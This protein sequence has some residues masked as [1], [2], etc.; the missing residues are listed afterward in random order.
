[1]SLFKHVP[2][3]HNVEVTRLVKKLYGISCIA[4]QLPSERDQNFRLTSDTGERFVF[5]IANSLE[6]RA[7]LEAQNEVMIHLLSRVS[8][9]PRVMSTQSGKPIEQV[10]LG[11]ASHFV[12]LVTFIPGEPM[13]N[14]K[15]TPN[16]RFDLGKTLGQMTR[17][18]STFDHPAFHREFHW[19]MV[20]A[21]KVIR[22]YEEL[23]TPPSLREQV[24]TCVDDRENAPGQRLDKLPRSVIH[25][26]ANDYN[27]IVEDDRVVGLIDFG[28]MIHSYTVGELAIAIAY[29]VLDQAD[30]LTCAKEVVAGYVSESS[31][32]EDELDAIWWLMLM[33]LSMS[34]CLAAHQRQQNPQNDYLDIS[35][36]SIRNSLPQLLAIDPRRATELFRESAVAQH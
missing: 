27:I 14:V 3:F 6:Q 12:R 30:P 32:N 16:L 21:T 19:D 22:Q 31:L 24:V 4:E 8:F 28:D 36:Q 15:Q 1:M 17:A 35:Q 13:A 7:L 23:V 5:K 20:N 2:T 9:C 11:E 26:D 29:V 34:V 25:G 18:L 33:R 10:F